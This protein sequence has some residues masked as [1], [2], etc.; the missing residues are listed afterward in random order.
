MIKNQLALLPTEPAQKAVAIAFAE[1]IKKEKLR[2]ETPYANAF[3]RAY[4]GKSR[5]AKAY[6]LVVADSSSDTVPQIMSKL[7]RFLE[8]NGEK[9]YLVNWYFANCAFPSKSIST[10]ARFTNH[11]EML[12]TR[13]NKIADK[14]AKLRQAYLESKNLESS[15]SLKRIYLLG[16]PMKKKI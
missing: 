7:D 9:R 15:M 4:F 16:W 13:N 12:V 3:C 14:E 2:G 5:P 8:S 10:E 1:V 6:L 11:T